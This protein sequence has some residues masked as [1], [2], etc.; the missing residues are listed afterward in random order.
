MTD[1]KV[2]DAGTASS[3]AVK[4]PPVQDWLVGRVLGKYELIKPIGFGS[5]ANIYEAVHVH[6]RV[7]F[8]IKVL[9]PAFINHEEVVKRFFRE[10]Q[11]ASQLQH[12]NVVFIADFDVQ[13]DVGPYIVMEYLE[14]ET[15]KDHIARQGAVSIEET[16]EISRQICQAL[17]LAHSKGIIHRDLKPE[18]IFLVPRGAGRSLVKILDFG[19]AHLADCGE[20]ITGA[21]LMGTPVYMAPEQFRGETNSR[22][23]DIYSFGVLLYEMLNGHPPF[24]GQNV[25]QLGI[26]HLLIP[27]PELSDDFP[28]ALR[29][30]QA[31]LLSKKPEERPGSMEDVW[32]QLAPAIDPNHSFTHWHQQAID[33]ITAARLLGEKPPV[34]PPPDNGQHPTDTVIEPLGEYNFEGIVQNFEEEAN[35]DTARDQAPGFEEEDD[36]FP[37]SKYMPPQVET[38][39]N[40]VTVPGTLEPPTVPAKD[41]DEKLLKEIAEAP[42]PPLDPIDAPNTTITPLGMNGT[43][44]AYLE[45]LQQSQPTAGPPT[46]PPMSPFPHTQK[47][48]NPMMPFPPTPGGNLNGAANHVASGPFPIYQGSSPPPSS[49]ASHFLPRM[50]NRE[51]QLLAVVWMGVFIVVISVFSLIYKTMNRSRKQPKKRAQVTTRQPARSQPNRRSTTPSSSSLQQTIRIQTNPP[52]A[53][54]FLNNQMIGTSPHQIKR[55]FGSQFR[56]R[57]ELKGYVTHSLTHKVD[58]FEYH[59][60]THTFIKQ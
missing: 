6:L 60:I 37:T 55:P 52:G 19:I 1:E 8:A 13:E 38:N 9:H 33:P 45:S 53:K 42:L 36:N 59:P 34:E 18:N 4:P 26:E 3:K 17:A 22:S 28:P 58:N 51:K 11:A 48:P 39:D 32:A 7:P 20:S 16:G 49:K 56:L 24:K 23:L 21:R 2:K 57:L 31:R 47:A 14:G 12:E 50:G 10:G 35:A 41:N 25:Q 44:E 29:E 30:L 40:D 54:I 46:P 15:L 27:A 43:P 5:F